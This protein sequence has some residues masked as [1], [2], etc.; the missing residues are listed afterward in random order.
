MYFFEIPKLGAYMAI[1]MVVK[2]YLNA[3][4]FDEGIKET[5]E[6][7]ERAEQAK[8]ERKQIQEEYE[9]KLK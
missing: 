7:K 3:Q 9:E 8:A 4:S 6:Y 1:P 2:S 5:K